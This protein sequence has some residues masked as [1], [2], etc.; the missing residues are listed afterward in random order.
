[1]AEPKTIY[2]EPDEEVTSVIDKLRKTEFKDVVL[3]VPKEAGVLHSIVNLKLIKKQAESLGKNLSL[4]TQDKVGRNIAEKVGLVTAVKLSQLPKEHE[5]MAA[6]E[7]PNFSVMGKEESDSPLEETNEIVY[8]K[9]HETEGPNEL[10]VTEDEDTQGEA[11]WR[12]KEVEKAEKGNIMP[13]LPKKKLIIAVGIMAVIVI[14]ASLIYLPRAKATI[15]VEAEKRPVSIDFTGDSDTDLDT[16]KAIIPAEKI[17]VTKEST[18]KFN[19]TG[20]RDEGTRA[21]GSLTISNISGTSYTWVS[22]TRFNPTS[23]SSLIYRSSSAITIPSMSIRTVN[24]QAAEPGEKYNGF[25]SSQAF[26]LTVGGLSPLVNIICPDGMSGGTT[27]EVT[28]VT[29]SDFNTAKDNYSKEV[30]NEAT[31][32]FNKQTENLAVIEESKKEQVVSASAAPAVGEVG[33]EFNMTVKVKI[34]ALAYNANDVNELVK[35]EVE[36]QLGGAK[37]IID[38]GASGADVSISEHDF[39]D[40][41]F[42]GSVKTEAYVSSKLD[43]D[44]IKTELTGMSAGKASEYLKGLDG[45]EDAKFNFWPPF[46]KYFPR[47]ANHIAIT[48]QVS[49]GSTN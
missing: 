24:V 46:I 16:E 39:E 48:I 3:V 1:M 18:K 34:S 25:G 17:E 19:A 28:Y 47:L 44:K 33:N 27:K 7:E 35:A 38:D 41:T 13:R 36:R 5:A 4:V 22:G 37:Q 49:E 14:I 6:A 23:N 26:T 10:T 29:Q 12:R 43:Q 11:D 40:G 2:L 31:T 32:E 21:T 9:P 20:K 42:S 8:K 15:F 30:M 45:V